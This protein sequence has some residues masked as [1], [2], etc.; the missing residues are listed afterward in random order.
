MVWL[1]IDVVGV[2]A[3]L[4]EPSRGLDKGSSLLMSP[5]S[6]YQS[7]QSLPALPRDHRRSDPR[8]GLRSYS[9]T[10]LEDVSEAVETLFLR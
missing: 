7:S 6:R 8:E 9:P 10:T 5:W 3:A 1:K 2:R 4:K